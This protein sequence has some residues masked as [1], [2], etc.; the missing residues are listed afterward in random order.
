[1]SSDGR[2]QTAV[3]KNGNIWMSKDYGATWS[4]NTSV[5]STKEWVGVAMSSDGSRQTAVVNSKKIWRSY[6]YGATWTENISVPD[7]GWSWKTIEMSSSGKYQTISDYY[8]NIW[9][10]DTSVGE[11]KQWRSLA[12]SDNGSQQI[13]CEH[14]GNIWIFNKVIKKVNLSLLL[15]NDVN[16]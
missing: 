5:G 8:G 9:I 13:A 4:E 3:I 12:I 2:R 15:P 7:K 16:R 14:T 1:M 11:T 6:D 10:E